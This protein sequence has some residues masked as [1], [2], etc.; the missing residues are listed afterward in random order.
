MFLRDRGLKANRVYIHKYEVFI[1]YDRDEVGE[2]ISWGEAEDKYTLRRGD[3]PDWYKDFLVLMAEDIELDDDGAM[4]SLP[5]HVTKT[6]A[7][8]YFEK[9]TRGARPERR[10]ETSLT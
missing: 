6:E 7:L 5:L 3:I 10:W 2:D 1:D 4:N 8:A 9:Y